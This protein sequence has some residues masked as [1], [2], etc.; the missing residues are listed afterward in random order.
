MQ[1][2]IVQRRA[3][4]FEVSQHETSFDARLQQ[5]SGLAPWFQVICQSVQ[6]FSDAGICST[7][8]TP[9]KLDGSASSCATPRPK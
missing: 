9:G 4:R 5:I 8:A 7:L 1:E 2:H 3:V 6:P